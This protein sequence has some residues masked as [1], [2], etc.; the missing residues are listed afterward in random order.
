M[1]PKNST[2]FDEYEIGKGMPGSGPVVTGGAKTTRDGVRGECGSDY[3]IGSIYL[4][5]AGKIYLKVANGGAT[6]DW[7]KVTAT[8]AD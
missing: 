1:A 5:T 7:Q 6:T 8:A 4:S 3:A 2:K